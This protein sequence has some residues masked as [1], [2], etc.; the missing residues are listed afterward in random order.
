MDHKGSRSPH[1][2]LSQS[3][4]TT[5]GKPLSL[6]YGY[7]HV[8]CSNRG[9]YRQDVSRERGHCRDVATKDG[10]W[11]RVKFVVGQPRA[12][13]A[14]SYVS[15]VAESSVDKDPALPLL[16]KLFSLLPKKQANTI[17]TS[18]TKQR[19]VQT[20]RTPKEHLKM[21]G[22]GTEGCTCADCGCAAGACNCGK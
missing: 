19:L 13:C 4:H 18:N 14:D 12:V 6:A 21:P 22:C 10:A 20:L 16:L 11:A 2:A 5:S 17:S 3:P 1:N 7:P 8:T 15:G 9:G